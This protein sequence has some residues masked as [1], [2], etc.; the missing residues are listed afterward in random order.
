[1][2][3][4]QPL[5]IATRVSVLL[6]CLVS[7]YSLPVPA[8]TGE[9][10]GELKQKVFDLTKQ[11]KYTEA[12]PLLEKLVVAEPNNS[13][14]HF[15]LGFA[16][17]GQANATKDL[18]Q[19]KTLRVRARAAFMKSQELGK[20]APLVYAMIHSLPPDGSEGPAFSQNVA[21]NSLMTDA[22]SFFSQGK[23]DQALNNYQKALE[24][25]P[26]LYHAALFAGD[27][28][29]Q[30]GDFKQ[31]EV[32]Y[33]RAIAIDPNRETAYRYSA[34]PLMKQG[35]T[36]A[37]RDRYVEAFITEPFS[38]FSRAGLIQWA[39][40]T[41][42]RLA[43]P[44]IA[45]PTNVT[46]D[47]KGDAKVNLDASALLGGKD[48]G[49]FAWISYGV[50]R[51]TWRKELFAKRMPNE[52]AYRHSLAEEAEALRSVLT[53]AKSDKKVKLSSSLAKLKQ[54]DDE[55]LLEAYILLAHADDGIATDY[56]A[57]LEKNRDKLRRYMIEYVVTGGG[58]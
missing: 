36:E 6:F 10:I 5:A 14:V 1:M 32:W 35:K 18:A 30:R 8:Q 50:T 31:A 13:E 11:T 56:S 3:Q 49:S 40:A 17:I 55:G 39:Q 52:L 46:F 7:L 44:D 28:F 54:L 26:K 15:F 58:K 47:E 21:A 24:L 19:R 45:I 53:I 16:L 23:L 4:L 57:Y 34:T 27:V 42:T 22:E 20:T 2:S 9:S 25:D 37:A 12:L 48:D 43:H 38:K 29:V 51:S 41:N 33:T